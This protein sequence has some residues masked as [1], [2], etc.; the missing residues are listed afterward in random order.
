MDER[1]S[2]VDFEQADDVARP[3]A[4]DER[5]YGAAR[6]LVANAYLALRA[7][8]TKI[9]MNEVVFNDTEKILISMCHTFAMC[10]L[11]GD[12]NK[13]G[14]ALLTFHEMFASLSDVER[15]D[16]EAKMLKQHQS[17]SED[18]MKQYGLQAVTMVAK[19]GELTFKPE[20]HS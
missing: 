16:F 14:E 12:I 10:S 5:Y 7:F 2:E 3:W 1:V 15:A 4:K 6:H 8:D 18:T 17:V 9:Q 20:L 19:N 13:A 11:V